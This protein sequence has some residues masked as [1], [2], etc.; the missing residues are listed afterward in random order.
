MRS[1]NVSRR[2]MSR[3]RRSRSGPPRGA[4]GSCSWRPWRS[5]RRRR[6]GSRAA[7]PAR[8]SPARG[9]ARRRRA[10]SQTGPTTSS[11]GLA[12][13]ARH[14]LDAMVRLVEGG[15]EQVVHARVHDHEAL[16]VV[17]LDVEDA[18]Q[19]HAR[20]PD[21]GA[22]G[23]E[24]HGEAEVRAGAGSDR[25]REAA[26]SGP[27]P[28]SSSMPRP[29]PMSM[30]PQRIPARASRRQ[31]DERPGPLRPAGAAPAIWLPMWHAR[32]TS[33]PGSP[34]R[35]Q[36]RRARRDVHAELVVA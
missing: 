25:R 26:T 5:R 24:Q 1:S 28:S 36:D 8:R 22:A 31:R 17:L 21:Q 23:L 7:R 20:G 12:A 15:A 27:V 30:R 10:V 35:V 19:Q 16:A 4:A 11:A 32:P 18:R 14:G 13:L 2:R 33:T 3:G 29:P 6:R 9:R 34:R